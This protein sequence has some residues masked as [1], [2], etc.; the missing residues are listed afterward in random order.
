MLRRRRANFTSRMARDEP[1]SWQLTK[2]ALDRAMSVN[3]VA[4]RM[5][6]AQLEILSR[7]ALT[8]DLDKS[9]AADAVKELKGE[10]N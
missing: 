2:G 10:Y 8:N 3:P 5:G 7:G 4:K 1:L 6:I 9:I